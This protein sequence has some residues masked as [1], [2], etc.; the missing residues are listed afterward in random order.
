MILNP[1]VIDVIDILYRDKIKKGFNVNIYQIVY[2]IFL[3]YTNRK[4]S[5]IL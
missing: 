4:T 3:F 1:N 5:V 2:H